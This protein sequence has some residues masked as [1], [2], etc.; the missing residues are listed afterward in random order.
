MG[1]KHFPLKMIIGSAQGNARQIPEWSFNSLLSHFTIP[2]HPS[3]LLVNTSR[4]SASPVFITRHLPLICMDHL[5]GHCACVI[6]T[7][8]KKNR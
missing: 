2:S 3:F 5:K 7:D 1:N 4:H 8:S 6:L